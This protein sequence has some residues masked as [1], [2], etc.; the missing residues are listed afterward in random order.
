VIPAQ[1]HQALQASITDRDSSEGELHT[2][3]EQE[4]ELAELL[5]NTE[6]NYHEANFKLKAMGNQIYHLKLNLRGAEQDLDNA[7]LQKRLDVLSHVKAFTLPYDQQLKLS[8]LVG[9]VEA[10][11]GGGSE[12]SGA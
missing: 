11:L 8:K 12:T 7:L 10:I 6:R 1:L 9:Q 5:K 3:K 2:I 4:V